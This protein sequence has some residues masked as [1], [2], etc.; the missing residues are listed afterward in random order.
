VVHE[1]SLDAK[2]LI[3]NRDVELPLHHCYL[4]IGSGP[5]LCPALD[6]LG[7]L[8]AAQSLARTRI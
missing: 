2:R 4:Q 7:F 5:T 1:G 3:L 8:P 6:T